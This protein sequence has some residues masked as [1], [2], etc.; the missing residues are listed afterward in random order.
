MT[1]LDPLLTMSSP[2][3]EQMSPWVTALDRL[4]AVGSVDEE[5]ISTRLSVYAD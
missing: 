5:V 1:I 2:E 3:W 4:V